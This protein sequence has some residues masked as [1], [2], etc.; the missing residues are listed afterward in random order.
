MLSCHIWWTCPLIS[1][2][3]CFILHHEN[4]KQLGYK[5]SILDIYF[6]AIQ[7]VSIDVP[8]FYVDT[9][10]RSMDSDRWLKS[11]RYQ[12]YTT[13]KLIRFSIVNNIKTKNIVLILTRLRYKCIKAFHFKLK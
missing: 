6:I 11:H 7:F 13:T 12:N 3:F 4:L 9:L 2:Y 8:Q 1:D 5:F 10:I